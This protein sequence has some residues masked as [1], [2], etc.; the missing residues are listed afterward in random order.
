MALPTPA[1][2]TCDIYRW[3]HNPPAAPDV[4]A[5]QCYLKGDFYKFIEKGESEMMGIAGFRFTHF[6]L[7]SPTTD[8]RDGYDAGTLTPNNA[9]VVYVPDKNG[10]KFAVKYV[11]RRFRKTAYEHKKVYLDRD[12]VTWPSENF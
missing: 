1:N 9:D 6:M 11:E 4:A 8:I 5:V 2:N 7:V 3:N 10:T 12:N